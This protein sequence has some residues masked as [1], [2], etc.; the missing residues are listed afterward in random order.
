MSSGGGTTFDEVTCPECG[1]RF[2]LDDKVMDHLKASWTRTERQRLKSEILQGPDIQKEIEKRAA[3]V[4]RAKDEELRDARK[5]NGALRSQVTKLNK[6]LPSNRTQALGDIRQET[7]AEMLRVRFPADHIDLVGRGVRGGDV[8]QRVVN[9]SGAVCGSILWESKR[10]STWQPRWIGKLKADQRRGAHEAAVIVSE[11][12]P[13]DDRP[14]SE[15]NGIW[16]SSFD[17]APD[18][19]F[20]LRE[21]LIKVAQARLASDS[22]ADVKAVTYSY[23]TGPLFV[24]HVQRVVEIAARLRTGLDKEEKALRAQWSERAQHISDLAAEMATLYGEIR[25]TGAVIPAV[26]ALELPAPRPLPVGKGRVATSSD[27]S[28]KTG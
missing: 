4:L 15:S 23:V 12:L 16:I 7:L 27:L 28:R 9:A 2:H 10:T 18:L 25:G 3:K 6:K 22:R 5:Q 21:G 8:T 26:E 1:H 11:T 19:A 24:Q 17:T 20:V 13:C 14:L